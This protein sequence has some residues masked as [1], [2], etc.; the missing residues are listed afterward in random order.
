MTKN[1]Y[2][3]AK[4]FLIVNVGF[5]IF[6]YIYGFFPSAYKKKITSRDLASYNGQKIKIKG[7]ICEE[8]DVDIKS[9]RLTFCASGRVLITTNLYPT[10]E[11]GDFLE[12]SGNLEAPP[13]VSDFN[14]ADYL[15]RYD[16][17]S[18][19]YYPKIKRID[20][21]LAKPQQVYLTLLKIKWLIRDAINNNLPEPAAGLANALLLGYRRTVSRENLD[22]FSRV[23]LSH[24]IA[25]SGS[26]ITI[27]SA[28][29]INFLLFLG[30]SRRRSFFI[31]LIF[32]I[33]YPLITGL[34]ASALRSAIM[35]GL[36]LLAS[37]QGRTSALIRVLI[38]SASGML[39]FNPRLLRDDIGF[40]LSFLALLGIIYIYPLGE[41]LIKRFLAKRNIQTKN[42]KILKNIL[43]TICLTLVSQIVI[44]PISLINFHQLSLIAP[45]ANILVLWTFAPLLAS[46]ILAIILSL[47]FPWFSLI[48]F[49]PA[50][51]IISY[52]IIISR[53]LSKP[54]WAAAAISNFNWFWG[55]IYYFLLIAV[56]W[57]IRKKISKPDLL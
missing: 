33:I 22:T 19:L 21:K 20:S 34:A 17:Y 47:I 46:L 37:R 39:I 6:I 53:F 25:I 44:L 11:Y 52:I 14:Y 49:F 10:Y 3:A 41:I 2:T 32:L 45:L 30:L 13:L 7:Y 54:G 29:I 36:A 1:K 8:A 12:V 35:G 18:V 43:E 48:F 16:I 9:R 38:F 56:I 50:Y 31:I 15:A 27:L 4:I 28:M 57:I 24:M 26:H 40:Q 5:I 51:L 42:K 23:G 55:A